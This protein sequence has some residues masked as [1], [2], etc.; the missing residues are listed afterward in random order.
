MPLSR[1]LLVLLFSGGATVAFAASPAVPPQAAPVA[2]PSKTA[3]A[4]SPVDTA[5]EEAQRAAAAGDVARALRILEPYAK[6]PRLSPQGKATLGFLYVESDKPAPALALLEPLADRQDADAAVLYNAARA[7]FSVH[8]TEKGRRWLERSAT[9]DAAS[10]A[11]RM[12]GMLLA[13]EGKVIPAYQLLRFWLKVTPRDGDARVQAAALALVLERPSEAQ[14]LLRGLDAA[15]PAIQLLQAKIDLQSNHPQQAL[16]IL[17]PLLKNHP[18]QADLEIR[19]MTASAYTA[20]G[21]PRDAI[22]LLQ[23]KTGNEP[24]ALVTLARAQ[25]Q[26]GDRTAA[27]T[28]LA[29]LAKSLPAPE[30]VGD[31]RPATSVALEYGSLLVES[32]RPAE[33]VPILQQATK[34][35]PWSEAAWRQLGAALQASGQTVEAQRALAE[36]EKLV[37]SARPKSPPVK[38]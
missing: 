35:S 4:A 3:P 1:F 28:T 5:V 25:H 21:K 32:G 12:L 34:L 14:E 6:D 9:Q 31:P 16:T 29:P 33:A 15:N 37:R 30:K 18:P 27:L 20:L 24:T 2:S 23:G 7:A 11:G 36:A 8:Q 17:Q 26:A 19:R 38:P 10:P 22:A 13:R